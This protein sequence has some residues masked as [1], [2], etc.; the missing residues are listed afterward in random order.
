MCWVSWKTKITWKPIECVL[1][2]FISIKKQPSAE[3]NPA[4]Q[5]GLSIVLVSTK[6][7]SCG[8]IFGKATF[9]L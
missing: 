5:S 1:L 3:V 8:I 2:A 4:N 6:G 7:L 9:K